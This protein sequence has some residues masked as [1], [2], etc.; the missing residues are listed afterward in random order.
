LKKSKSPGRYQILAELIQAEGETSQ[1][2]IHT[3]INSIWSKQ[4]LPEQWREYTT[5]QIYEKGN[6]SNCSN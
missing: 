5:V 6:K 3:I 4:E 1:S 2:E